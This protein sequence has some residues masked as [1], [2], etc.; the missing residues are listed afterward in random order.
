MKY[1][2]EIK[3][4]LSIPLRTLISNHTRKAA[5]KSFYVLQKVCFRLEIFRQ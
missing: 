1:N 4:N 5:M 2:F 3:A